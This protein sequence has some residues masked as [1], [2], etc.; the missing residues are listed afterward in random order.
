M[1]LLLLLVCVCTQYASTK[2]ND[3]S[4]STDTIN[5]IEDETNLEYYRETGSEGDT[6]KYIR[7]D[8]LESIREQARIGLGNL[9]KEVQGREGRTLPL[10]GGVLIGLQCFTFHCQADIKKSQF[11]CARSQNVHCC[12]IYRQQYLALLNTPFLPGISDPA[13]KPTNRP[14]YPHY[15]PDHDDHHH[16]YDDH[17]FDGGCQDSN[18]YNNPTL[19]PPYEPRPPYTP[20]PPYNPPSS[21]YPA[22]NPSSNSYDPNSFVDWNTRMKAGYCPREDYLGEGRSISNWFLSIPNS[23]PLVPGRQ[24]EDVY[25]TCRDDF[26]CLGRQKC[27]PSRLSYSDTSSICRYPQQYLGYRA[28]KEDITI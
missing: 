11:C 5:N 15:Y 1:L 19:R 17:H 12:I 24:F 13:F 10:I 20:R 7:K 25:K 16:D 8:E 22:N 23:V 27:C 28:R 18:C 14:P 2:L 21:F 3:H 26:D 6:I 4:A 9:T